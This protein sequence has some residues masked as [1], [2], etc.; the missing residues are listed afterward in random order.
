MVIAEGFGENTR[1]VNAT[2]MLHRPVVDGYYTAPDYCWNVKAQ[3][4]IIEYGETLDTIIPWQEYTLKWP[5]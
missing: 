5:R 4:N 3:I 2:E 1:F